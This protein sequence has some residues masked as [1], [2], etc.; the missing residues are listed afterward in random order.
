MDD[1]DNFLLSQNRYAP[2]VDSKDISSTL[3]STTTNENISREDFMLASLDTK[4]L[5]MFDELKFIRN[6]Q[7][8]CSKDI[9]HLHKAVSNVHD[10]VIETANDQSDFLKT[11]AYKLIDI[12][13][14]ARRNS[15]LFRGFVEN[16][17]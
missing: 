14:R 6:S 15:L 3:Q 4:M 9:V 1:M 2:L 16:Y 5:H 10:R 8:S 11:L 13:A 17:G 7:V 12:E